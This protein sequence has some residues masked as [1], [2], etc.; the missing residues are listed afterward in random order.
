MP[1]IIFN[2]EEKE[3]DEKNVIIGM[4]ERIQPLSKL[5]GLLYCYQPCQMSFIDEIYN[6]L[7]GT[8][9]KT[10]LWRCLEKLEK[11]GLITSETAEEVF[12][13]DNDSPVHKEIKKRQEQFLNKIPP[14]FSKNKL[15]QQTRYYYL[16]KKGDEYL[17]IAQKKGGY[18]LK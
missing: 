14:N 4:F 10:Y 7:F 12:S 18:Q 11:N 8:A 15:F 1:N 16:T 13:S 3:K 17:T 2:K 9:D 6:K 5:M